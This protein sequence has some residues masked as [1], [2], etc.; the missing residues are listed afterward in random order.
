MKIDDYEG[1]PNLA[2]ERIALAEKGATQKLQLVH[3]D[4]MKGEHR[5]AEFVSQNLSAS[6][7]LPGLL[8]NIA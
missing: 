2:R 6:V 1:F 4:V 5:R 7:S 8:A 3:V